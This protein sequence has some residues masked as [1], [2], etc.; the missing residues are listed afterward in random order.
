MPVHVGSDSD[1][2]SDSQRRDFRGHHG[3]P[4]S[5]ATRSI[6]RSPVFQEPKSPSPTSEGGRSPF[7]K[8]DAS[9]M[10]SVKDQAPE[11]VGS[12]PPAQR[13]SDWDMDSEASG[14]ADHSPPSPPA[15]KPSDAKESAPSSPASSR[16][17]RSTGSES[18]LEG[19]NNSVSAEKAPSTVSPGRSSSPTR[20]L[21]ALAATIIAKKSKQQQPSWDL[22]SLSGESDWDEEPVPASPPAPPLKRSQTPPITSPSGLEADSYPSDEEDADEKPAVELNALALLRQRLLGGS[23]AAPAPAPLPPAPPAVTQQPTASEPRQ[24]MEAAQR[25]PPPPATKSKRHIPSA[26]RHYSDTIARV[27]AQAEKPPGPKATYSE[28]DEGEEVGSEEE[29]SESQPPRKSNAIGKKQQTKDNNYSEWDSDSESDSEGQ[30]SSSSDSSDSDSSSD[31]SGG[32]TEAEPEAAPAALP[33]PQGS[34]EPK[35]IS[36][37]AGFAYSDWDDEDDED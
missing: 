6:A 21:S 19:E 25:L 27:T 15:T 36:A 37:D 10:R 24:E 28:W 14:E 12:M 31:S 13:Y 26:R 33:P 22:N 2:E 4:Q 11:T 1:S 9:P 3:S 23:A 5:P 8:L 32:D 29:P 18:D 17:Q 30:S 20:P 16:G 34:S 7:V 35:Q